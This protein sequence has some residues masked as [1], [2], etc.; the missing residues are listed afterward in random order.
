[1]RP[2]CAPE[3]IRLNRGVRG[4]PV[5][6]VHDVL[7]EVN[8][9]LRGVVDE[10]RPAYGLR[11]TP[12]GLG[13]HDLEDLARLYAAAVM[14]T[15]CPEEV[16]GDCVVIGKGRFGSALAVEVA[17]Q[18]GCADERRVICLDPDVIEE[19]IDVLLKSSNL[20]IDEDEDHR[21][22]LRADMRNLDADAQLDVIYMLKPSS[23]S[24]KKWKAQVDRG[25]KRMAFCEALRM[26]Y[27]GG[28][29]SRRSCV[30]VNGVEELRERMNEL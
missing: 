9:D 8:A 30:S 6:I 23:V 1:M 26:K 3:I 4:Y 5:V 24:D 17:R 22:Q 21:E 19:D 20:M 29:G 11:L 7:G 14:S 2:G 10:Q 13:L 25:L 28:G 27:D 15:A 12:A 16:C 18:L